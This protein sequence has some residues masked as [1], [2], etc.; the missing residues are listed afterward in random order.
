M[1]VRR[2]GREDAE[3][4]RKLCLQLDRETPYR[5]YGPG[6][7]LDVLRVYAEEIEAIV[8]NP[9][10]CL[11][12]AEEDGE[13]VGYLAAY[14]RSAPRVAH[15][16]TVAVAILQSHT[17]RGIGRHLF[18]ALEAWARG[19][20]VRRIDLTV[21]TDNEPALKLYTRL[22]FCVEG[23]KRESMKFGAH[24]VDEFYMSKLL[25]PEARP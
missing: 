16:V 12:A 4:Y 25:A 22:G 17:G 18:E 24:Y 21:M 15:V 3:A 11:I 8:R 19:I 7:R 10:S 5:L 23:R 14:G 20:G 13:L 1:I 9:R 6:E 2:L